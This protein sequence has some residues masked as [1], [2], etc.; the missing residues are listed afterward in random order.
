MSRNS[1]LANK[2]C[3]LCAEICDIS[4]KHCEK[5]DDEKLKECA[6]QCRKMSAISV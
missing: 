2:I 4:A 6:E 5:F 3:T 1:M